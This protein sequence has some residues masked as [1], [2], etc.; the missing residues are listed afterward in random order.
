M[1]KGVAEGLR[2]LADD[3]EDGNVELISR[4]FEKEEETKQDEI[5]GIV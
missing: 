2:K 3:I 5:F 1:E 4:G